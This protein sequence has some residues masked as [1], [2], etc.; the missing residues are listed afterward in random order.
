MV[1]PSR[2]YWDEHCSIHVWNNVVIVDFLGA[3]QGSQIQEVERAAEGVI[4]SGQ[5]VLMLIRLG[6]LAKPPER[7]AREGITRMMRTLVDHSDGWA[8]V[9]E[10]DGF[11]GAALRS[12]AAGMSMLRTKVVPQRPFSNVEEGAAW[13]GRLPSAHWSSQQLEAAVALVVASSGAPVHDR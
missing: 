1:S 6:E 4:D 9:I 11:L 12:V 3:P 13:L 5:K 7:E 10:A 2:Q 8:L